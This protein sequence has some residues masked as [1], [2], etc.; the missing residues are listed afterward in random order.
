M[1]VT[2]NPM[3]MLKG[4]LPIKKLDPVNMTQREQQLQK[5]C[6]DFESIFVDYMMK[7]MRQ[8]VTKSDVMGTSQAEQ[9]YTSMLDSEVANSVSQERGLGLASKMYDQMSAV[10]DHAHKKK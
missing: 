6:R 9:I 5:A 10:I 1:P 7:Q 3:D 8:T 2:L 4:T